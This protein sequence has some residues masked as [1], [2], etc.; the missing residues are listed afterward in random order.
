M[1]L[2]EF[3]DDEFEEAEGIELEGVDVEGVEV[4]GVEDEDE[5]G[6]DAEGVVDGDDDEGVWAIAVVASM[7]VA[8][9][10]RATFLLNM[11]SSFVE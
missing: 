5:G 11:G 4:D 10:P 7:A 8:I 9:K 1:E 3:E 6:G 2:I